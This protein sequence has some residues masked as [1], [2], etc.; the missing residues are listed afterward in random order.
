MMTFF[1]P[2]T[3]HIAAQ[4]SP[5][6]PAPKMRT[7]LDGARDAR[8]EAWIATLS[9]SRMAPSSRETLE[10]SLLASTWTATL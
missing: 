8:R 9:G 2:R 1:A 7:V 4:R 10:G 6:A 3:L 5:T